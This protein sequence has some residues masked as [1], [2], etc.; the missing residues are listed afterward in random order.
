[1]PSNL[2]GFGYL[3]A[4]RDAFADRAAH[5]DAVPTEAQKRRFTL[6]YPRE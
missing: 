6:L 3:D 5:E 1:M 4:I 2:A